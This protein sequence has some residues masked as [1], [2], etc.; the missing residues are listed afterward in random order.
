M[1][2]YSFFNAVLHSLVWAFLDSEQTFS[3]S[4]AFFMFIGDFNGALLG[5]YL[6]K[7]LV[8]AIEKRSLKFSGSSQPKN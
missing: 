7:A 8:D 4:G 2:A 3:I 6:M 1:I 5:A